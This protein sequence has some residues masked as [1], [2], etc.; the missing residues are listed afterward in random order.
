MF[1]WKRQKY[2]LTEELHNRWRWKFCDGNVFSV[3]L[4]KRFFESLSNH[5]PIY[6]LNTSSSQAGFNWLV[7]SLERS[8]WNLQPPFSEASLTLHEFGS[9]NT[10]PNLVCFQVHSILNCSLIVSQKN[11]CRTVVSCSLS[12]SHAL[13]S[14]VTRGSEEKGNALVTLG[15]IDIDIPQHPVALHSMMTRSSRAISRHI[16][17]IQ[18]QRSVIR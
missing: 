16:S 14:S 8:S 2:V 12:R 18:T 11:C 13:Y 5:T 15:M 9:E 4:T 7:D 1:C 6:T 10:L 3:F 17:E